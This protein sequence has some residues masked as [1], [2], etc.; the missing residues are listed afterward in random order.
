MLDL[1]AIIST[2]VRAAIRE[3][4]QPLRDAIERLRR[5]EEPAFVSPSRAAEMTGLSVATIR[6]R[7]AD[8]DG[9]IRSKKVGGRILVETASLQII[10]EGEVARRAAEARQ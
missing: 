9:T 8:G 7:L 5:R 2:T 6:R 10:D 1:E 3:E 4:L